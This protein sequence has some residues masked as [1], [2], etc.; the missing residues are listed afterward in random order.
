MMDS[1]AF[2]RCLGI[3]LVALVMSAAPARAQTSW[4]V[5]GGGSW[6]EPT[7]WTTGVPTN[8]TLA[9]FGPNPTGAATVDLNG[10]AAALGI[11]VANPG[12]ALTIN[13][14]T[15]TNT[16]TLGASGIDM[17][18]ATQNLTINATTVAVD[19]PQLWDV[20]QGKV[21][22]V[23]S[24]ITLGANTLTLNT[25]NTA[26]LLSSITLTGPISGTGGLTVTGNGQV[27]L[28]PSTP[29]GSSN[30][31]SGDLN[32]NGGVVILRQ[33]ASAGS[34]V[35]NINNGHLRFGQGAFDSIIDNPLPAGT[36]LS[37]T[38]S[39]SYN[40]ASLSGSTLSFSSTG[41]SHN[42]TY[43]SVN[44]A[45]TN[46]FHT[47][48]SVGT[49][50]VTGTFT[51]AATT[52][53]GNLVIRD[54]NTLS[55]G[56]LDMSSG[57][58]ELRMTGNSGASQTTLIIGS[59]GWTMNSRTVQMNQAILAGSTTATGTRIQLNGPV[60]TDTGASFIVLGDPNENRPAEIQLRDPA[61]VFSINGSSALTVATQFTDGTGSGGILKQGSGSLILGGTATFPRAMQSLYTGTTQI[62]GG[63]IRT[64]AANVLSTSSA[65]VI[66]GSGTLN[67]N[68]NSQTIA[69]L[70]GAGIVALG[71]GTLT[72]G[73][74]NA[75]TTYSGTINGS[76]GLTKAG[77]GTFTIAGPTGYTGATTINGGTLSLAPATFLDV[78][79]AVAVNSTGTFEGTGTANG[80]VTVN[81]GGTVSGG[82]S[83]VGTLTIGGDL[84]FNSGAG[85]DFRITS[86]GSPAAQDTGGS[87][88]GAPPNTTNNNFI[89][90]LGS[91]IRSGDTSTYQFV[92]DGTGS[93]FDPLQSYSYQVGNV[94]TAATAFT[95]NNPAQFSTVGF[96]DPF[97]F[98]LTGN[99]AGAVY[100]NI[101]SP[102]PEPAT[103]LGLAAG[104]LAVGGFIRRR[105]WS[106]RATV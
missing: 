39:A 13:N 33:T 89:N 72:T 68:G 82:V 2:R 38:G 100:L 71:A 53:T 103:V 84:T 97:I 18:N 5:T 1:L 62:D 46:P 79:S 91:F 57:S 27:T 20:R 23:S 48:A 99:G 75:S 73:G 9:I 47:G 10:A 77:S 52:A 88:I 101:V 76:G 78:A 67:L 56:T 54:R 44:Y 43:S 42:Q 51:H 30:T 105:V 17:V 12:G 93:T 66:G 95:F 36:A 106:R 8:A 19:A 31:F 87:S 45:S 59:G 29:S 86:A 35:V 74:S 6:N 3:A 22:T 25:T 4:N 63:Q 64:D 15:G 85:Q 24:A 80:S 94:G 55:V 70:A 41:T 69:S 49:I 40:I 11:Q 102:V 7:N 50:T 58:G 98:S 90:V 28:N 81:T 96:S 65:V 83:G 92:I 16:L 60:T 32:I 37:L 34:T 26:T 104:T 21:L 14:G 61:R